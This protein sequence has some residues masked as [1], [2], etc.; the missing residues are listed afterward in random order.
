M[1]KQRLLR[2]I[3]NPIAARVL[4]GLERA[5]EARGQ[6]RVLTYHRVAE[7]DAY[8][9]LSP[10]L[11]SATP[12]DF[13]AQMRHVAK[14]YTPVSAQM[15][16]D[17]FD[18]GTALPD[19]AILVTFDDAYRDFAANAWP[20]LKAGGIPVVLFV[21]TA[22]PDHPERLLWWDRLY[23]ALQ[24]TPNKSV[25]TRE[26]TMSLRTPR[27]KYHAYKK[28][29]KQVKAL[30][31]R[32]AMHLV[33]TLCEQ[34]QVTPHDDNYILGWDDLKTLAAEGV[35]L[36]AH[37]RT[38]P[39]L[40]RVSE[41]EAEREAIG[42]LDDLRRHVPDVPPIFAYP[43]GDASPVIA[44]RLRQAGL[45]LAF[46]AD[47]G[48]NRPDTT[49]ELLLKRINVGRNTSINLLRAKLLSMTIGVFS[50]DT[51]QRTVRRGL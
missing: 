17:H 11:F 4:S 28:I 39:L 5:G 41:D 46:T 1:I 15:V 27:E 10:T 13:A 31:H 20:V 30:P 40:N 8:P 16:L 26:T 43:G 42:S 18:H 2:L 14:S 21:P 6:L 34:L 48:I 22:Y 7:P 9:H 3:N 33:G 35:T 29:A 50:E 12:S 49:N 47:R 38:H 45:R 25:I 44:A 37:T 24:R 32:D 36:G 51:G 19:R 23:D